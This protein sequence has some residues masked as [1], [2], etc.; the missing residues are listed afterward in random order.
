MSFDE[1]SSID[2]VG[3]T[4]LSSRNHE[5]EREIRQR[6]LRSRRG[7]G[8]ETRDESRCFGERKMFERETRV[9]VNTFFVP[10]N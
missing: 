2:S 5:S 4:S 10:P 9:S 3:E 7:R 8:K 6:E 1:G